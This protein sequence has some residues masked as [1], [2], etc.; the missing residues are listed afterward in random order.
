MGLSAGQTCQASPE[1][2]REVGVGL[3]AVGE[4]QSLQQHCVG[5]AQGCGPGKRLGVDVSWMDKEGAL[6]PC[7]LWQPTSHLG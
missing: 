2:D 5:S 4:R 6:D 7:T 1:V 3:G